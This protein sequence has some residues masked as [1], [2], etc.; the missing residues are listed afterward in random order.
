MQICVYLF[1]VEVYGFPKFSLRQCQ[2]GEHLTC[3]FGCIYVAFS[4]IDVTSI[5]LLAEIYALKVSAICDVITH[6]ETDNT[7]YR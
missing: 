6:L 1:F 5:Y 4:V 7:A 3:Q 2:I